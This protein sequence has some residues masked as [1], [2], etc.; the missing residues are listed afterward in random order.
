MNSGVWKLKKAKAKII[1]L[2]SKTQS[3]IR[4]TLIIIIYKIKIPIFRMSTKFQ[5]PINIL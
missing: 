5:I 2:F 3:M 4:K 1:N